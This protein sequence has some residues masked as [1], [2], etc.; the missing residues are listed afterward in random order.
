MLSI[1]VIGSVLVSESLAVARKNPVHPSIRNSVSEAASTTDGVDKSLAGVLAQAAPGSKPLR[2]S[3]IDDHLY[4][5]F[6]SANDTKRDEQTGSN[7]GY[8]DVFDSHGNLVRRLSA[9]EHSDSGW[10]LNEYVPVPADT[11]AHIRSEITSSPKPP[12]SD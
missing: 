10:E 8:L 11:V 6:G 1:A 12:A 2:V 4:V 5:V 3:K 9:I 7:R